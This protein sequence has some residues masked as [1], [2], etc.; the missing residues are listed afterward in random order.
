MPV[1]LPIL[2]LSGA[3]AQVVPQTLQLSEE[4]PRIKKR[5]GPSNLIVDQ[6]PDFVNREHENF[7]RFVEVYYEWLEQYQNAFGIIDAVVCL[8]ILH[9][10][11]LIPSPLSL[12]SD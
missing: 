10:V 11:V 8:L 3:T 6:V 1:G 9:L 12:M 7:R 2:L 5:F 4:S